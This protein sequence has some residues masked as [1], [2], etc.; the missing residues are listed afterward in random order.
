MAYIMA[1]TRDDPLT[2]TGSLACISS[3]V[4]CGAPL[5]SV[6]DVIRTKSTEK[7]PFLLILSS[8]LVTIMWFSY[9]FVLRDAFIQVPNGIGAIISGV[10]LCLFAIYPNK[11]K[12]RKDVSLINSFHYIN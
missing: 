6:S 10:Q 7:L 4:F 5:V 3:L 8:F 11:P 1:E 12:S 2:L 9:G